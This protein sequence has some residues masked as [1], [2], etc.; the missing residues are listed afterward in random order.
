MLGRKTQ[1]KFYTS[2]I[3]QLEKTFD[4]KDFTGLRKRFDTIN[5]KERNFKIL[6]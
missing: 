2:K 1:V 5:I 4:V 6:D 3:L